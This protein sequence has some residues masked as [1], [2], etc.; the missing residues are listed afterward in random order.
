VN[1]FSVARKGLDGIRLISLATK[2]E[3]AKRRSPGASAQ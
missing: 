1:V 3:H 2:A